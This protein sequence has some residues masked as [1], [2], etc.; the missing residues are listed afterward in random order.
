MPHKTKTES[1]THTAANLKNG[2][3]GW[4]G[5]TY[6][7]SYRDGQPNSACIFFVIEK[8]WIMKVSALVKNRL[9]ERELSSYLT[10]LLNHI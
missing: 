7:D 5:H 8:N 10:A 6:K 1:M 2:N 9:N 3:D 4:C